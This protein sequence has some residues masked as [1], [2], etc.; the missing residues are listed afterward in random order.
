MKAVGGLMALVGAIVSVASLFMDTTIT[1]SVPSSYGYGT[2]TSTVHNLGL[3]Q[4]QAFVFEA[5]LALAVAGFALLAGGLVVDALRPFT[6]SSSTSMPLAAVVTPEHDAE[7]AL[8]SAARAE[9]RRA[10]LTRED[11][12]IY[13][14]AGGVL[15]FVVLLVL[16]RS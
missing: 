10:Q 9:E 14:V 3:L 16:L 4:N 13:W 11:T 2:N 12:V 1:T 5:G 7:E 8:R 15:A 6:T